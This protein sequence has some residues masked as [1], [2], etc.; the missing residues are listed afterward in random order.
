MKV[1]DIQ[2]KT[3][4]KQL[5][6][7]FVTAIRKVT[8]IEVIS[9][10][11]TLST[12]ETGRG[13]AAPTYAITGESS[14]SINAAL[15]GPISEDL[16]H[17]EGGFQQLL[18]KIQASCAGNSSAKAA[19]DIALHEAY[20]ASKEITLIELLG[21]GPL[22]MENDMTISLGSRQHMEEQMQKHLGAGYRI[23]KVKLGKNPE[24]DLQTILFLKEKANGRALF[25]IDANQAWKPKEAIHF[26]RKL[27]RQNVPL[28]LIEQPVKSWDLEGLAY[29]TNHVHT[30]VM[31]DESCATRKDA[32]KIVQMRAAD[33]INIKLMKSG[34]IRE[35]WAVA[36]IAEAAGIPCMMGSM[37]ESA[38]S[39]QAAA[40]IANAH[41]NITMYDLDAPAWLQEK[42]DNLLF[43][44]P[45]VDLDSPYKPSS[46]PE[47]V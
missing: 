11:V 16:L 22:L 39:V 14:E 27:E 34:G 3:T 12:G 30:P 35:A 8:K 19:M 31:A 9:V 28:E 26:I 10:S 33:M 40:A 20:A 44:S 18:C 7:P 15:S 25:R 38:A 13:A 24:T 41:P 6:E 4:V 29:V 37:M 43:G 36:D 32:L 2:T 1:T 21:G 45:Y 47:E 23:L 17:V 42:S 46:M 5:K